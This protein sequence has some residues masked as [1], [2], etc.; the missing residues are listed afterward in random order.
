MDLD[1]LG[2]FFADDVV[3]GVVTGQLD[4]HTHLPYASTSM[5]TTGRSRDNLSAEGTESAVIGR[6]RGELDAWRNTDGLSSAPVSSDHRDFDDD[7]YYINDINSAINRQL[8]DYR[9]EEGRDCVPSVTDEVDCKHSTAA[10]RIAV[11]RGANNRGARNRQH[12]GGSGS[13]QTATTKAQVQKGQAKGGRVVWVEEGDRQGDQQIDRLGEE[14]GVKGGTSGN[15]SFSSSSSPFA[16][17]KMGINLSK[18]AAGE[19][20]SEK[21]ESKDMWAFECAEHQSD[22]THNKKKNNKERAASTLHSNSSS[23]SS[24]SSGA[25]LSDAVKR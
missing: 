2:P 6:G 22:F 5:K 16:R 8:D 15:F 19:Y 10:Q 18:T 3:W 11:E 24:S 1:F 9:E 23:S 14:G 7:Q 20:G 13:A 4:P 12:L 17:N 21:H 25:K